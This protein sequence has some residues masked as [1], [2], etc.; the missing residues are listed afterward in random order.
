M[1]FIRR[2]NKTTAAY[3]QATAQTVKSTF[4][5][6]T[7]SGVEKSRSVRA[8]PPPD[9]RLKTSQII[10]KHAKIKEI[11]YSKRVDF[12]CI[13]TIFSL[14]ILVSLFYFSEISFTQ[15][16]TPWGSLPSAGLPLSNIKLCCTQFIMQ[17]CP[18]SMP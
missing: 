4:P 12:F 18:I 10:Q 1:A 16:A 13:T 9:S 5:K 14:F 3:T 2:F 11:I 7:P 17:C 15:P 8:P 6:A